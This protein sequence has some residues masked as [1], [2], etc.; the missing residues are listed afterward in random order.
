MR[1]LQVT[2]SWLSRSSKTQLFGSC[3]AAEGL[4]SVTA[5]VRAACDCRRDTLDGWLQS[6]AESLPTAE[7]RVIAIGQES[8]PTVLPVL[9]SIAEH[10]VLLRFHYSL[11][12]TAVC[13]GLYVLDDFVRSTSRKV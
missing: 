9:Q 7:T 4:Q 6:Q 1:D 3:L 10:S 8:R 12:S 2:K 5:L 11:L 13:Y